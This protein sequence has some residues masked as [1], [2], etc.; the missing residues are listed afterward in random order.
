MS[1]PTY[2]TAAE[3]GRAHLISLPG[4]AIRTHQ[5]GATRRQERDKRSS[6]NR[7]GSSLPHS[8]GSRRRA[9]SSTSGLGRGRPTDTT[10][11]GS[12]GCRGRTR[13]DA[14][15]AI[16]RSARWRRLSRPLWTG[17]GRAARSCERGATGQQPPQ[18]LTAVA[19]RAARQPPPLRRGERWCR[20]RVRRHSVR[21]ARPFPDDPTQE[22]ARRDACHT[23]CWFG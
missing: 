19:G 2:P 15:G 5:A 4:T 17:Y 11:S 10:G 21:A 20:S 7:Q 14:S 9:V 3:A 1:G 23:D 18:S 12:D 22:R 6:R 8:R 16:G 13:R